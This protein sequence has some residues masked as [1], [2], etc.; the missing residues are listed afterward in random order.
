MTGVVG[1]LLFLSNATAANAN[2]TAVR[3]RYITK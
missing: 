2:A 1:V 3:H